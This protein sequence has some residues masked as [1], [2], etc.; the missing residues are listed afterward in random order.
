MAS[1]IRY[2]LLLDEGAVRDVERLQDTYGLRNRADVYDLAIRVLNWVTE[3]QIDGFDVGRSKS[4]E[5]QPL[6]LPYTLNK[7][8]WEASKNEAKHVEHA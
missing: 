4:E 3:Q 7:Q 1:S 8:R 6:L 2:T 5:F